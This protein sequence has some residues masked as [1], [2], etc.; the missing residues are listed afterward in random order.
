[1]LVGGAEPLEPS[2]AVSAW[3]RR[4]TPPASRIET[5]EVC[6]ALPYC[7]AA[8]RVAHAAALA[9]IERAMASQRPT[10]AGGAGCTV[11]LGAL[12][13]V[14]RMPGSRVFLSINA[15][16]ATSSELPAIEIAAISGRSNRPNA[17]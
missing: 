1:M 15:L 5:D 11:S 14:V 4:K 13:C 7:R 17:G 3:E 6:S 12:G 10:G 16:S 2:C 9:I 8:I